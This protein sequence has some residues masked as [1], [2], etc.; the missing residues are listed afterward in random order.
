MYDFKK[1]TIS[2]MRHIL[3]NLSLTGYYEHAIY[4]LSKYN[5]KHNLQ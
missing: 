4:I 2:Y 5:V 3:K 1:I